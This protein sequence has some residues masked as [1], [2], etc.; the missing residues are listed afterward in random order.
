M[1]ESDQEG[2]LEETEEGDR[3]PNAILFKEIK[4]SILLDNKGEAHQRHGGF[5]APAGKAT[6]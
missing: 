1:V 6:D 3:T 5:T 4:S 2:N